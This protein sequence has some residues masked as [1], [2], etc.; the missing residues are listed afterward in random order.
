MKMKSSFIAVAMLFIL[1]TSALPQAQAQS[2]ADRKPR[3]AMLDFDYG[4]VMSASS[5]IFGT[6]V[7]I[8]KGISAL[9]VTNLVKNGSYS[10]IDRD[11]L[12]KVL[13]EQN[14]SNSNRADPASAARIGRVLGVDYIIVGTITEFGNETNKQ[15]V[16]GGGANFHGFGV[17]SIGH[18]SSK[19]NVVINARIV[20]TDTAEILGAAE[21]KGESSRRIAG[22]RQR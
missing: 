11:A 1:G 8:G 4:T 5:S 12:S 9:L 19:A 18:S 20:N 13:A 14:F 22:R 6:N 3:V 7:D 15:N 21:G 17:G 10:V 16:G 2:A